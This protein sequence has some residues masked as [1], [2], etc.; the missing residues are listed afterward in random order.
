MDAAKFKRL[1]EAVNELQMALL[2]AYLDPVIGIMVTGK[3]GTTIKGHRSQLGE[4]QTTFNA[5]DWQNAHLTGFCG[6]ICAVPFVVRRS[7]D[8]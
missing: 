6:R 5:N 1:T 7:I 8:G 3:T 2:D 4:Y